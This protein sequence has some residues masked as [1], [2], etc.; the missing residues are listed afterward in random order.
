MYHSEEQMYPEVVAWFSTLLR[1]KNRDSNVEVY[2]TARISLW[3]FIQQKG[4]HLVFSDY[5][6]YDIKVDITGIIQSG[7]MARLAFVECKLRPITLRDVAQLLGYSRVARPAYA[8]ILSPSGISPAISTLLI[9]YRR[10][11]VLEYDRGKRI[12]IATWNK[13]RREID[14]PT[15]LPPG[16]HL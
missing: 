11:D 5:S 15:L 13:D 14:Y 16:E 2:I 3:R 7:I 1:E 10:F 12:R 6:T 4:L 9:S 8:F